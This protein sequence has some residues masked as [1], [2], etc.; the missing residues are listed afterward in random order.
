MIFAINFVSRNGYTYKL[1]N[2]VSNDVQAEGK[3]KVNITNTVELYF[4]T[5]LFE[6]LKCIG[7]FIN[8]ITVFDH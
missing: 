7:F 6:G 1:F 4:D 3:G 8:S 5:I 2:N